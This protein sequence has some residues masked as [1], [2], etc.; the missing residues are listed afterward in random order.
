MFEKLRKKVS[1]K[2]AGIKRFCIVSVATAGAGALIGS[3]NYVAHHQVTEDSPTAFTLYKQDGLFS[4]SSVVL[5]YDRNDLVL[6]RTD[7]F[8]RGN[9]RYS[10]SNRDGILDAV[11][12]EKP[13]FSL[14]GVEGTFSRKDHNYTH[15]KLLD[16]EDKLYQQELREFAEQYQRQ[17]PEKFKQLGL[18]KIVTP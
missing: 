4:Y 13:W 5:S 15:N 12:I 18:E 6:Y 1:E 14:G 16:S 8:G 9:R 2:K 3:C 17:Y 10:D 11:E 7:L